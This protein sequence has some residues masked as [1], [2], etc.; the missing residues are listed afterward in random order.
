MALDPCDW[1]GQNIE[2]VS[3]TESRRQ[4]VGGRETYAG[5][6]VDGIASR[7]R[8]DAGLLGG[9]VLSSKGGE[10]E[11]PESEEGEEEDCDADSSYTRKRNGMSAREER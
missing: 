2:A 6:R 4:R 5:V 3:V 1:K 9:S 8:E 7:T 11:L 10:A